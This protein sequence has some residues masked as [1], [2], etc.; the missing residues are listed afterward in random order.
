MTGA[1]IKQ[2]NG[3]IGLDQQAHTDYAPRLAK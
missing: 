1:D 3:Y 2:N